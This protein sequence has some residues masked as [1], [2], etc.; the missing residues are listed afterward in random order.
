MEFLRRLFGPHDS[1]QSN[2]RESAHEKPPRANPAET[3]RIDRANA[4]FIPIPKLGEI[5]EESYRKPEQYWR[6]FNKAETDYK[7]KRY[8]SSITRFKEMEEISP[9]HKTAG[10]AR[11]RAYR[12]LTAVEKLTRVQP[13]EVLELFTE[14]FD[15]C[16]AYVTDTD[17]R[18][19]NKY[20]KQHSDHP[21][22]V[23]IEPIEVF[24]GKTEAF[25][26]SNVNGSRVEHVDTY[27]SVAQD[28]VGR[29]DWHFVSS[30]KTGVLR[31]RKV[32]DQGA[33]CFSHTEFV[34]SDENGDEVSRWTTGGETRL[35]TAS[36]DGKRVATAT[37][38][39]K[40]RISDS[41][42]G[43]LQEHR[44]PVT[45]APGNELRCISMSSDGNH[46]TIS[47]ADRIL[48]YV[49]GTGFLRSYRVP[50]KEGW[51]SE[52][53]KSETPPELLSDLAM[54][55]VV[56][57]VSKEELKSA[58]RRK[59]RQVHPDLNPEV[60]DATET[61]RS[62]IAS[63][64]RLSSESASSALQGVPEFESYTQFV[65]SFSTTVEIGR[66]SF[67]FEISTSFGGDGRDWVT[68]SFTLD[69]GS[70]VIGT[71]EGHVMAISASANCTW[72]TYTGQPINDLRKTGNKTLIAT[73]HNIVAIDETHLG[74]TL[75]DDH[76]QGLVSEDAF[77]VT[78]RDTVTMFD[79][80]CTLESTI[81]FNKTVR[82]VSRVGSSLFVET[83]VET[84]RYT[85]AGK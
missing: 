40:L 75:L 50:L 12:K 10:N 77:V 78:N 65:S 3:D 38:D 15:L 70:V 8:E 64:E 54:L 22:L 5:P 39:L 14:M 32:F 69:D 11:I 79:D 52:I 61:T 36:S 41:D 27:R 30:T 48:T 4:R 53:D 81:K 13:A 7:R 82:S 23:S 9:L 49:H 55:D 31:G 71:T 34:W 68:A 2:E 29:G 74:T 63:Y 28:L 20:L 24:G 47:I 57:P 26:I 59:L 45:P 19:F 62:L 72:R 25:L 73:A 16:Q 35:M 42:G 18:R 80:T 51:T 84:H 46:V 21:A 66:E 43:S 17:R 44:L 60:T 85:V 56:V 6:I 67:T 83:G 1:N 37:D 33:D 58:F 76:F